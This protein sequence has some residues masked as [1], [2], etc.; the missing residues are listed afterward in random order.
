MDPDPAQAP[1]GSNDGFQE[2]G[3]DRQKF[4][5]IAQLTEPFCEQGGEEVSVT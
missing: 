1:A 2:A 3:R 4:Y 5:R